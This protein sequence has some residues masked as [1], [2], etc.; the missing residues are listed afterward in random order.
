ME[1]RI[2]I[3]KFRFEV[4]LHKQLFLLIHFHPVCLNTPQTN[5]VPLK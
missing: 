5:A 1:T 3:V 4:S 2:T